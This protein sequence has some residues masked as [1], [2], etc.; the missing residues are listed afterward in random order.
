MREQ[1]SSYRW[2]V[3]GVLA[4]TLLAFTVTQ[5]DKIRDLTRENLE[6]VSKVGNLETLYAN[7]QTANEQLRA[8]NESYKLENQ[9]LR[10]T[11]QLLEGKVQELQSKLKKS[12]AT[13]KAI[14]VEMAKKEAELASLRL[15]I[16]ELE[17]KYGE[18]AASRTKPLVNQ[19][20]QIENQQEQLGQMEK[21]EVQVGTDIENDAIQNEI[22]LKRKS[23]LEAILEKTTVNFKSVE[24]KKT[25]SSDALKKLK[26]DGSNWIFT[27]VQFDLENEDHSLLADEYFIMK[28]VDADSGEELPFNESN[29]A[30][31]NGAG[32][33][34]GYTFQ[35]RSNPVEAVYVNMQAKTGVNFNV[36]FYFFDDEKEY[37]IPGSIRPLIRGGKVVK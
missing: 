30:F 37:L 3:G 21:D 7:E 2:L 5:Q 14:R 17:E 22:Q 36:Q 9:L 1:K 20:H 8:E 28:I 19:I 15:K 35:W 18:L 6:L 23:K 31:E 32:E 29:P 33:T 12:K 4:M 26:D 24:C 27:I 16:R 25:R 13:L 11:I 10:D 34:K